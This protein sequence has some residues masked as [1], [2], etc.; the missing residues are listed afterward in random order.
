MSLNHVLTLAH[1]L[2]DGACPL[3]LLAG[4]WELAEHYIARLRDCTRVHALDVWNTYADCFEGELLV[5]RGDVRAGLQLLE[6][7]TEKLRDRA[8]VIYLTAFLGTM[9]QGF[10]LIGQADK[11]LALIEQALARCAASGEA[12]YV[13]ELERL[14]GELLCLQSDGAAAEAAFER[15][16]A[17]ARA[18]QAGAWERRAAASLALLRAR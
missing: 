9:A 12:W 13:P 7:A 11:G 8:F 16:I 6:R 3:A 5:Q 1:V 4:E 15:A 14:R 17:L 10:G 18:Q 2:S